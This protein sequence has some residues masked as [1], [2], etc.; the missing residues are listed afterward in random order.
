M[1][2]VSIDCSGGL[3]SFSFASEDDNNETTTSKEASPEP[4]QRNGQA[5][6]EHLDSDF[7]M[8][9][10]SDVPK[11]RSLPPPIM[12][13]SPAKKLVI[14][15]SIA[16]SIKPMHSP[17][18]PTEPRKFHIVKVDF[19][20]PDKPRPRVTSSSSSQPTTATSPAKASP[21]ASA[22]QTP[23]EPSDPPPP[24]KVARVSPSHH[25]KVS[26]VTSAVATAEPIPT[27]IPSHPARVVSF[28]SPTGA[29]FNSGVNIISECSKAQSRVLAIKKGV[30]DMTTMYRDTIRGRL[31]RDR[32]DLAL[33]SLRALEE[34]PIQD[35]AGGLCDLEM[36]LTE[37][38]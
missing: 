28:E 13:S 9:D 16:S 14:E 30:D 23:S 29:V 22:L 37:V 34:D 7:Q 11:K 10:Q 18:V 19:K 8:T 24:L 32:E 26:A 17:I 27:I 36:L 31:I 5:R 38:R 12:D 1:F 2:S 20:S 6:K 25:N 3:E 21:V 4:S 15:K 33:L 35:I